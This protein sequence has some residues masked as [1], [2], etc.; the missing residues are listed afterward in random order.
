MTWWESRDN[1]QDFDETF[2]K[3]GIA[4]LG[5][6]RTWCPSVDMY[7][8]EDNV[9][10]RADLPGVN[11]KDVELTLTDNALTIRGESKYERSKIKTY[12]AANEPTATL[13]GHFLSQQ[14]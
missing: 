3:R 11:Q 7:E 10:V 9:V 1:E 13:R 14:R 4:R 8:T 5:S 2:A 6:G 12:T